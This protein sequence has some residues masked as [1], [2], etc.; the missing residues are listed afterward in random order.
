MTA[1]ERTKFVFCL[2]SAPDSTVG[3]DSA[4]PDR[5]TGLSGPTYKGREKGRSGE[6]ERMTGEEGNGRDRPPFRKFLDP[7]LIMRRSHRGSAFSV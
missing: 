5:L 6:R 7:P 1:L 2:G 3:A 4:S